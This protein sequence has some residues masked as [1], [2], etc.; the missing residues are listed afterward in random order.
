MNASVAFAAMTSVRNVFERIAPPL[1]A[2]VIARLFLNVAA[3]W[4]HQSG[5]TAKTW[6][7]WDSVHYLRIA[8]SGYEFFSC[9]RLPGY[10]PTTWCG[11]TGWM[12]GFP[13]LIRTASR[14]GL[15]P[16]LA[17]TVI[18]AIFA[19]ATLILL[20]N[21]FLGPR[22]TA[23]G[24][25]T[26]LL[27]AF[28]PGHVYAHAVFPVSMCAFLQVLALYAHT[29]HRYLSTGLLGGVGAFT[30]GSGLFLA[31]V[32]GLDILVRDR[33]ERPSAITRRL[34]LEC[35]LIVLGFVGAL[36]IQWLYV[37]VWNGYFAVQAKYGY[38]ATLPWVTII[39]H[40]K[41][42]VSGHLRADNAQTIFVLGLVVCFIWA[43]VRA[44]KSGLDRLFCI[45]LLTYWLIP[46]TLGGNLSLYRVEAMLLPAVPL[47]RK[48]PLPVL[49]ALVLSALIISGCMA[50]LFFQNILV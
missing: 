43:A 44:P 21:F 12:P 37:G 30:Y 11:N 38:G 10:D 48:L 46:L 15:D 36:F 19:L 39:P 18:A 33:R 8:Q 34:F 25:L 16:T 24:V 5:W 28:F 26:L 29:R 50:L 4:T 47:A 22:P 23:A 35:G 2:Y 1:I 41:A 45:F 7:R 13:L 9:A 17:G 14:F 40:I 3:T 32:F 6:A 49:V 31:G 20:W 42:A 27:A